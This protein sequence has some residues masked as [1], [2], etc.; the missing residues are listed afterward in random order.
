MDF[1]CLLKKFWH[2]KFVFK[3]SDYFE[4]FEPSLNSVTSLVFAGTRKQLF[5]W[6]EF[7]VHLIYKY[8]YE[9]KKKHFSK[10]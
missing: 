4:A 8:K 7:G 3:L 6:T 1:W 2:L 9:V 5:L 10:T